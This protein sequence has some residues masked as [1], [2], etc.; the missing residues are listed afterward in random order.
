MVIQ[1]TPRGI[2]ET[3]GE[4]NF[5]SLTKIKIA[6]LAVVRDLPDIIKRGKL[7]TDNVEN[8]HNPNSAVKYAY[9][10]STAIIDGHPITINIDVRKSPDKIFWV[11]KVDFAQK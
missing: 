9:T 5:I 7:L 1:I 4:K 3:F 6:K 10:E 8:V 2:K 11:H